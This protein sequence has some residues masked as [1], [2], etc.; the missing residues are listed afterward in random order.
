MSYSFYFFLIL[1]LF[2]VFERW[3]IKCIIDFWNQKL[4][5]IYKTTLVTPIGAVLTP[6]LYFYT[7]Y[8][9]EFKTILYSNWSFWIFLIFVVVVWY[10]YI[11]FFSTE[12]DTATNRKKDKKKKKKRLL[13]L[14]WG[15]SYTFAAFL[16]CSSL[17]VQIGNSD[18]N[19]ET[20]VDC[21]IVK[22]IVKSEGYRIRHY[23]Y[24]YTIKPIDKK[25]EESL[26]PIDKN[27]IDELDLFTLDLTKKICVPVVHMF[28]FK[29]D[30]IEIQSSRENLCTQNALIGETIEIGFLKSYFGDIAEGEN[31]LLFDYLFPL[32]ID[33]SRGIKNGIHN[34]FH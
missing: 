31:P 18:Y 23:S 22:A 16:F 28:C 25:W 7:C 4:N 30:A 21:K 12:R 9:C 14:G 33:K 11:N 6:I 15:I 32:L 13:S 34:R 20:M 3:I 19:S 5:T 17:L 1:I 2:L 29:K 8:Y 10:F 24:Y 26:L 27:S